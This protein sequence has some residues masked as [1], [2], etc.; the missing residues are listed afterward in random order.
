M[1][2]LE[3]Q[4]PLAVSARLPVVDGI[5][6]VTTRQFLHAPVSMRLL[7]NETVPHAPVC[8]G[9]ACAGLAGGGGGRAQPEIR[10]AQRC[11]ALWPGG[12]TAL[13]QPQ[14]VDVCCLD[15]SSGYQ[16]GSGISFGRVNMT[17]STALLIY[18][19]SVACRAIT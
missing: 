6:G 3:T 8:A 1:A 14:H 9:W 12:V 15:L 5:E 2:A 19:S 17:C 18:M 7:V 10:A 13:L 4:G 11:G 16:D